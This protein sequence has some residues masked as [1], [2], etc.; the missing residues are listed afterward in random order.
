MRITQLEVQAILC[1][2]T[3]L[4][5]D[6]LLQN[7]VYRQVQIEELGNRIHLMSLGD[8]LEY[9]NLGDIIEDSISLTVSD[10]N[11]A[12]WRKVLRIHQQQAKNLGERE[13]KSRLGSLQWN[14]EDWGKEKVLSLHLFAATM[15]QRVRIQRIGDMW[16]WFG[17]E[18][19]LGE[20]DGRIRTLTTAGPFLW[21]EFLKAA[22]PEAQYWFLYRAIG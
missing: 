11:V 6:F 19:E 22:Y 20:T 21:P 14:M 4:L 8:F 2:E 3:K 15:S 7:E 13:I 9:R 17:L 18:N 10:A 12:D 1:T 16:G 5:E